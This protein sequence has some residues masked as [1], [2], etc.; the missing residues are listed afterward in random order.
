MSVPELYQ[1]SASH[2]NEKARW[3][4]DYKGVEHRRHSLLPGPHKL[5]IKKISGQEQ[6]PV[7]KNGDEIVVGS[8]AIIDHL[9]NLGIGGALY[10]ANA[11]AREQA[12]AI[13]RKFDDEVGPAVRLAMFHE[14]L[15]DQAYFVKMFSWDQPWLS[16]T[17]Y[18]AMFPLVK[19]LM[20]KEMK[21]NAENAAKGRDTT[22]DAFDF[23]I[24][25]SAR[26]GYLVGNDFSVADLT[27]ASLLAPAVRFERS[28][29]RSPEPYPPVLRA[30]WARWSEHPGTAWVR[31]IFARHRPASMD[32]GASV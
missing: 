3:A 32:I 31:G 24:R 17:A 12:L 28:P 29:F 19:G 21:I 26:S 18:R 2:F 14:L 4:L 9:E 15:G 10:P 27:A 30:W 1:F 16:R 22:H 13:Q 8:A 25:E 11:A 5:R 6:V 20:A 7:L 23:V